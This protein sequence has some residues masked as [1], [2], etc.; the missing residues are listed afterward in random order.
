MRL[1]GVV[2]AYHQGESFFENISTYIEGLDKLLIFDNNSDQR[3]KHNIEKFDFKEK[4]CYVSYC[5]NLG[6]AHALNYALDFFYE[7]EY[8]LMMDQDSRFAEGEFFHYIRD[9]EECTNECVM[10]YAPY[11]DGRKASSKYQLKKRTITSGS[12]VS[13]RRAVSIGGF[14]EALFIDEVDHEFCYRT[15]KNG[16][17]IVQCNS[18]SLVHHLGDR[19]PVRIFGFTKFVT[20]H[21][22]LRRYYMIRNCLYVICKHPYMALV[23]F[24]YLKNLMV[25]MIAIFFFEKDRKKKFRCMIRGVRDFLFNHMGAMEL[26]KDENE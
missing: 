26:K 7:Y 5:K 8:L 19:E 25:M 4:V 10:I 17:S 20:N 16:F 14:D 13:V 3:L 9:I 1:V 22:P 21:S 12:V 2:T 18:I 11:F 6:I 15:I 24:S 23:E